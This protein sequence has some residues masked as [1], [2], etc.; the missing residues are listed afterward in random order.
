M[1]EHRWTVVTV[2]VLDPRRAAELA[3]MDL[4]ERLH[5][6]G[7]IVGR[8]EGVTGGPIVVSGPLCEAC[9]VHWDDVH[10]QHPP[11]PCPGKRP[12]ELGGS[13][14]PLVQ[15]ARMSRR[16]LKDLSRAAKE[17][18]RSLLDPRTA[19]ASVLH[20]AFAAP[21]PATGDPEPVTLD[22]QVPTCRP[23]RVVLSDPIAPSRP[24]PNRRQ[25]RSLRS[26]HA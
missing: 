1:S 17:K 23:H 22:S 16:E 4:P 25:R 9:R 12:A 6:I 11:W 3:P 5:R 13:L 18:P 2:T 20:G 19:A 7:E 24:K 8:S 14:L 15:T 10:A 26:S 21:E